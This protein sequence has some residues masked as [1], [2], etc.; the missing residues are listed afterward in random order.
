MQAQSWARQ[1]AQEAGRHHKWGHPGVHTEFQNGEGKKKKK[2]TQRKDSYLFLYFCK[3]FDK[4]F[5]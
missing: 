4:L 3:S 5:I 1:A 2:K